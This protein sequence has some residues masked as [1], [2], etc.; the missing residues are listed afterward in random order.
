MKQAILGM[1]S[2]VFLAFINA[3]DEITA[4]VGLICTLTV[5]AVTCVVQVYR[6]WR[7]RDNDKKQEKQVENKE[8][9]EE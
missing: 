2:T 4:W 3:R 7:D 6:M 5:T 8:N 9:K 1:A